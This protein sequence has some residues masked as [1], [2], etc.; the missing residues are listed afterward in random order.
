MFQKNANLERL[1]QW[2]IPSLIGLF[3]FMPIGTIILLFF[4]LYRLFV[5]IV[6]KIKYRSKFGGLLKGSDAFHMTTETSDHVIN[7][8]LMFQCTEDFTADMFYENMREVV[9]NMQQRTK[10][11]SKFQTSFGYPYV[12]K[13]E[14]TVD[15]CIRQMK[16]IGNQQLE[17]SRTEFLQLL[18]EYCNTEL[19]QDNTVPWEILVGKQ[20]VYWKDDEHTYLPLLF[21]N[22]HAIAD[23]ITLLQ[24]MVSVLSDKD[25]DNDTST[26]KS[27]VSP[28]KDSIILKYIKLAIKVPLVSLYLLLLIPASCVTNFLLKG[29]DNNILCG[30][31]LGKV[32]HF[33]LNVENVSRYVSIIKHIKWR[34]PGT[35]FP[36][37]VLAAFSASLNDYFVRVSLN[38]L[39]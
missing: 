14:L 17:L 11:N 13:N 18:N 38:V 20:S 8:L 24:V 16:I 9:R 7:S 36:D 1:P 27:E 26:V 3:L 12:K 35:S 34:V 10:F 15:D 5:F 37:V 29:K 2:V 4:A 25:E 28:F 23:G 22:Q 19:P 30:P 33:V 6:L 32:R 31:T 39:E 21:R